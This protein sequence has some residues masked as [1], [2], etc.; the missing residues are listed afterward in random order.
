M[1]LSVTGAFSNINAVQRLNAEELRLGIS[2]EASWHHQYRDSCYIYI[3]GLDPRLTEGD[4]AIVFS[5]WGEPIDIV[6]VRDQKTGQSLSASAS[7]SLPSL[8]SSLSRLF[9][10]I[11]LSSLSL[12]D[13]KPFSSSATQ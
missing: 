5:Q 7:L 2:G 1:A 10:P 3:S 8:L 12:H 6:L 13:L 11:S 9:L 4:V